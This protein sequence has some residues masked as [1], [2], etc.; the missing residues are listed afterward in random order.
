MI[1]WQIPHGVGLT[2]NGHNNTGIEQFLNTIIDSLTREVVQNS[3]DAAN[4][5]CI[6]PVVVK[7]DKFSIKQTMIP[8]FTEI[9]DF[10]LPEAIKYWEE[11]NNKDT[12]KYLDL[13]S[14]T[15]KSNE[16]DVLKISDFNTIGLRQ[17]NYESLIVGNGYSEKDSIGSAG[18]KGIGKAAPFAASNLRMVFYN[19]LSIDNEFKSAGIINFVTFKYDKKNT[20]QERL[21]FYN[22]ENKQINFGTEPRKDKEYGTDLFIIGLKSFDNLFIEIMLSALNNFLLS[23]KKGELEIVVGNE[24]LNADTIDL[25]FEKIS[26]EKLDRNTKLEFNRTKNFYDVLTNEKT[27]SFKLDDELV[28][29]YHFIEKSDDAILKLLEHENANRSI[30]QTR[31]AGMKIYER[32]GIN[33]NINFS[34]IFQASG[35]KLNEFLKDMENANHDTWSP[36]RKEG[37]EKKLAKDFLSDLY[38]WYKKKVIESFETSSEHEVEAFG[39]SSLL[40]IESVETTNESYEDSGINNTIK[41]VDITRKVS[42]SQ[43]MNGDSEEDKI[44]QDIAFIEVDDG[45][46]RGPGKSPGKGGTPRDNFGGGGSEDEGEK[47]I[48]DSENIKMKGKVDSVKFKVIE[49]DFKNG[50]Y[51]MVGVSKGKVGN[52]AIELKYIGGDGKAYT[53]KLLNVNS[54][55]HKTTIKHNKIIVDEIKKDD[56]INIQFKIN[57]KLKT[58]MEGSI[59]E[60]ES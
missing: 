26:N 47:G 2:P 32:K 5:N 34:G 25:I 30:L 52:I 16:I 46:N 11:K 21:S 37:K 9:N 55:N 50:L 41:K 22:G 20:T 39:I 3:L 33:G 56:T 12:L 43:M 57:S 28:E 18:S 44:S 10:A 13:F 31:K 53:L 24:K 45:E 14:E 59:Y 38:K 4:P 23:I 19:T 6:E 27:L 60:I 51:N 29:K 15:L 35:N 1:K 17:K 40:P 42:K 48:S 7:F 8:D 36:D 54:N 58:K 49:E